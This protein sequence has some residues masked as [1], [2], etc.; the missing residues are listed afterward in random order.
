MGRDREKERESFAGRDKIGS[1]INNNN[2]S[3]AL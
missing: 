3:D 2:N 1:V